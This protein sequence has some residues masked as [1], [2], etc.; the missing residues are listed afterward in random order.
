MVTIGA[1]ALVAVVCHFVLLRAWQVMLCRKLIPLGFMPVNETS[2]HHAGE[3]RVILYCVIAYYRSLRGKPNP[4]SSKQ[5][6]RALSGIQLCTL[7]HAPHLYLCTQDPTQPKLISAYHNMR[8]NSKFSFNIRWG[9]LCI[10]DKNKTR[11]DLCELLPHKVTFPMSELLCSTTVSKPW[12]W[13][14]C[15]LESVTAIDI[16]NVQGCSRVYSADQPPPIMPKGSILYTPS[17]S[18]S[19]L[20]DNYEDY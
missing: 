15:T 19:E 3:S 18:Q 7:P 8:L 13:T 9:S 10:R 14:H 16:L 2:N 4:H 20:L 5:V 1:M 11:T 6:V 17:M 12:F